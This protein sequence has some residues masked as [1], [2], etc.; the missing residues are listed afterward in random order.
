MNKFTNN[1]VLEIIEYVKHKVNR[2]EFPIKF[3]V[4]NPDKYENFATGQAVDDIIYRPLKSYIDIGESFRLKMKL[5]VVID[6][7]FILIEYIPNITSKLANN[8]YTEKYGL[9]TDYYNVNKSE[10]SCFSGDFQ[11]ALKFCG[12]KSND[13]ILNLGVNKGDEFELTRQIYPELS[14]NIEFTGIDHSES[15]ISDAKARF[16]ESNYN[17]I[18]G[19]IRKLDEYIDTKFN[20]IMSVG[21][22]QCSGINF[23]EKFMELYRNYLKKDGKI[24]LGFPNSRIYGGDIIYGAEMVNYSEPEMSLIIKDIHFCK[25]YLQQHKFKVRIFGKYYIFLAAKKVT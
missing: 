24:L 13:K 15:A 20:M 11:T 8:D 16:S 4:P 18:C 10:E 25:K 3:Q 23:N 22:L 12:L 2:V 21:T 1:H 19:D 5:P 7:D 17:F 6:D 9:G 14:K